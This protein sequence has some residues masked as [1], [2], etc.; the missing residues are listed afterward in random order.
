[1]RMVAGAPQVAHKWP[2]AQSSVWSGRVIVARRPSH[3]YR[4]GGC[5]NS[6]ESPNQGKRCPDRSEQEKE[7]EL[8]ARQD[9]TLL[10][11][12]GRRRER[13]C[14]TRYGIQQLRP[15]ALQA[16]THTRGAP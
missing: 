4:S 10:S 1:M 14:P 16:L 13:Y 11:D 5:T 2:K 6:N 3:P 12:H 9:V 15:L 7:R 8:S